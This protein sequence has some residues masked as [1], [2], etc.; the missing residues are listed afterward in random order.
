MIGKAHFVSAAFAGLL[1]LVFASPLFANDVFVA[2]SAAGSANGSSCANAYA[3][4]YFNTSGNWTSGVPSGTQIGPGTTVHLCGTFTESAGASGTLTIQGSGSSGSP[5]TILFEPGA[6]ATAPYWGN[7]GFIYAASRVNYITI[8][9]GGTG[10]V[11]SGTFTSNGDIVASANGAALA[12]HVAGSTAIAFRGIGDTGIIVQNMECENMFVAVQDNTNN[13]TTKGAGTNSACVVI[14]DP[15]SFTIQNN[16]FHDAFNPVY[17]YYNAPGRGPYSILKNKIYNLEANIVGSAGTGA[18]LNGL[19]IDNN[20][21]YNMGLWDTSNSCG[22]N[23][24]NHHEFL[25]LWAVHSGSSISNAVLSNNY[26]HGTLGYSMT[27]MW[28]IECSGSCTPP[29]ITLTA[30]NNL[31]SMD[32]TQADIYTGAGGNG[33]T[34]CE[35][36]TCSYYNNTFYSSVGNGST[37]NN[38]IHIENGTSIKVQNNICLNMSGCIANGG[39]TITLYDSMDCYGLSSGC[40]SATNLQ[41]GNPNLD[42][43]LKPTTG[44]AAIGNAANLTSLGIAGLDTDRANIARPSSGAW[45]IGAYSSGSSSGSSSAPSPPTGLVDAVQ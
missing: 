18:T 41:T 40:S 5:I 8:D 10:S 20:E 32:D 16:V 28:Y 29:A 30:Y 45:D 19:T 12:N 17:T 14:L 11:P 23:C 36:G 38:A 42:A 2:Q 27:A 35:G 6:N 21:F 37:A 34:E 7:N 13:E 44:S 31:V 15:V 39:G 22:G 25:H 33:M 9:G 43:N 4:S 1:L 26:F 24:P 3:A